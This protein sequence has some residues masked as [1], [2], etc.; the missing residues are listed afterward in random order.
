MSEGTASTSSFAEPRDVHP[1]SATAPGS[2]GVGALRH[3]ASAVVALL[4]V[5]AGYLAL[6]YAGTD[7]VHRQAQQFGE[8][9]LPTRTVALLVVA[10]GLFLAAGLAG[11]LSGLGPLLA[12]ILWGAVPTVWLLV[13][14]SSFTRR[15]LDLRDAVEPYDRFTFGVLQYSYFVFPIVCGL[16]LGLAVAG[17]WRRPA[18][19]E[20]HRPD[21]GPDY[22]GQYS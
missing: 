22:T 8:G 2:R 19:R 16:L 12:G 1:P 9:A 10:V 5:P 7:A 17:R 13:D 21:A 14:Y 20:W 6:D 4:A 18:P 15:V 11:R 3:L